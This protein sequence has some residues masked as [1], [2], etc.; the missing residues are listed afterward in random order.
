MVKKELLAQIYNDFSYV[1]EKKDILGI[2]LYGSY[3]K[4][5]NTNRSDIDICIVAPNEDLH[6]LLS[7]V[8][9]NINVGANKYDIRL[10]N[11]L[12]LYIKIHII[13]D[14]IL[15]YSPNELDLYEFF[16]IYRKLWEDQKHRQ[17]IS[18][19]DL[20]LFLK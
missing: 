18:K 14:G 13:E 12:P 2:L 1:I 7:F 6:Q 10:F 17:E 4:S 16:Y 19:E 20:L 11:E 5:E 9:Q 15:I 8:L 3:T